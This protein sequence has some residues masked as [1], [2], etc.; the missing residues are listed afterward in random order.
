[1]L[2]EDRFGAAIGKQF[3]GQ[4]LPQSAAQ[5]VREVDDDLPVV[6]RLTRRADRWA[7]VRDPA[8]GVGDRSFLFSPGCGRQHQVSIS[9]GVG[10]AVR[11]LQDDEIGCLQGGAHFG[12]I[13]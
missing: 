1:M 7:Q 9:G 12:L 4:R 3:L 10:V 2:V 8:L 5:A 11:L 13:G 6:T